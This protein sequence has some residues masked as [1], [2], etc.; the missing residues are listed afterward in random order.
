MSIAFRQATPRSAVPQGRRGFH[1]KT[2]LVPIRIEVGDESR[3]VWAKL[4]GENPAGSVKYRTALSLLEGLVEQRRLRP[5]QTLVES[6]SGNL[7]LALSYLAHVGGWRFHAIVDPKS[8]PYYLR[9]IAEYEAEY[10]VVDRADE[11]GNY[12]QARLDR[13]AEL[14]SS[15]DHYV[16]PNQYAST[17]NPKAHFRGTAPELAQQT[18][19]AL[20][21]VFVAV[22]TGGTLA[23]IARYMRRAKPEVRIVGVDARGSV[24]FGS[25]PGP[26]RLT[27]IGSTRQSRFIES[28]MYD[29]HVLVADTEAFA[30]CR[31][32]DSIG[33]DVGG[34]SGAV[35]AACARYLERHPEIRFPVCICADGHEP[36]AQTIY[37]DEWLGNQL[38]AVNSGWDTRVERA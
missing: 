10:E 26:R 29:D 5:G 18:N 11:H 14:S 32:L 1:R 16:W 12:L 24:V 25:E 37:D 13:V 15:S 23:G 36:Y 38:A 28:W 9:R 6:T 4:E 27:G 21:A 30:A 34:S 8:P 20:D 22:S 31:A 19:G 3:L 7:G 33:V 2:P 17:D 35:F